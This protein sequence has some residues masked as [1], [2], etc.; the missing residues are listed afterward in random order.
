LSR[1][2]LDASVTIAWCF[3]DETTAYTETVLEMLA[4]GSDALA[5]AIWPF[6][7]AN[8]LVMAERRKRITLAKITN[9]LQLLAGFAVSLDAASGAQTFD[10]VLS[11]AREQGL[12]TYDAAYLELAI[13]EGLPLATLDTDLKKAARAVGVRMA[14]V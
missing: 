13:R 5:P 2:V 7:V 8:V 10:K 4:A 14:G 6:E 9:F 3:A 1:F 11:L 12:S